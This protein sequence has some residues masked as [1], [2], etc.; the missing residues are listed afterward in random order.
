MNLCGWLMTSKP[1]FKGK[2]YRAKF[3]RRRLKSKRRR[4]RKKKNRL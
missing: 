2:T 1:S 4:S 3:K